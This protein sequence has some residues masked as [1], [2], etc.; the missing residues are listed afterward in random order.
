MIQKLRNIENHLKRHIK[1]QDHIIPKISS[2]I[3]RGELNLVN[4][5]RPKGS[6][7]FAGPTGTGKTETALCFTKYL[8]NNIPLLRFDMSEY[9]SS[10]SIGKLIGERVGEIGL[11][12]QQ[13]N[14]YPKGTL[15][16][17]EMEKADMQI[18]DLFL[19]ILDAGRITL[20]DG[21]TRDLTNYYIVFTSNIGSSDII[22]MKRMP[23]STIERIVL[24]QIN[25]KLRPEFVARINEKIVFNSL[26]YDIQVEICHNMLEKECKKYAE[27]GHNLQIDTSALNFLISKGFHK[28]LGARPM[29]YVIEKY[30]GDLIANNIIYSMN[31][32]GTIYGDCKND[33]LLFKED[34]HSNSFEHQTPE[35]IN[36]ELLTC[37]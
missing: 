21:S 14:L 3:R 25:E 11:L 17:D 34:Y 4:P 20:A 30:I 2:V 15:L 33:C 29:Q 8:G 32:S 22:N 7:L 37:A 1:G 10:N 31:T 16:F 36:E 23:F 26:S 9:M 5:T 19:Q 12:G 6:F 18:L 28:H 24:N 13:L 35:S 27:M